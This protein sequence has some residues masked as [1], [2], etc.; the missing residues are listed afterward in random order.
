VLAG[1]VRWVGLERTFPD[2]RIDWL[3]NHSLGTPQATN[4][5]VWALNRHADLTAIAQTYALTKNE[6]YAAG[7][8]RLLRSWISQVPAPSVEFEKPGSAWRRLEAGLRT[9]DAWLPA[10]ALVRQSPELSDDDLLLFLRACWDH[11]N[12]LRSARYDPTNHFVFAMSGLYSVGSVLPELRDAATWRK[13]AGT[14]LDRLLG[15]GVLADG[16]WWELAPGYGQWVCDKLI[17]VWNRADAQGLDAEITPRSRQALQRL[18]EWGVLLMAPERTVPRLNDGVLLRHRPESVTALAK[19]FP[20]SAILRWLANDLAGQPTVPPAQTS[21][22][23]NASGYQVMR[24]GWSRDDSYLVLDAGALG[25]WHGHQDALNVVAWFHGR[26]F[27]FDN[28][29]FKYDASIWRAW[30]QTTA[31]HNTVLVDGLGQIRSWNGHEDP[32]GLHPAGQP[33]PRFAKSPTADYGSAW[34][35]CGYGASVPQRGKAASQLRSDPATHRREVVFAKGPDPYALVLDT[36]QPA[37]QLAHRYEVRW[38][39]KSV[40]WRTA[41][42]GRI[43]WTSDP[44]QPNLA[45]VSLAGADRW[46]ADSGVTDPEPLGWWFENQN[47]DPVPALTLRHDVTTAGP[48]RLLTALIPFRADPEACPVLGLD[49]PDASTAV[50]RLRDGRTLTIHLTGAAT[51]PGLTIDH[52][53]LP[54]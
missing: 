28:G 45:I 38:H 35:A 20:D 48:V 44:G 32:I 47:A 22:D 2:G 18:A 43:T 37:D 39:L 4:E 6:R 14:Q 10:F 17:G 16:S 26:H 50:I 42:N 3:A 29:G 25:G 12:F 33:A 1:E 21:V 15:D 30:G 36:L 54:E 31:A 11:A 46:R 51:G 34:Y 13:I 8:I 19:R 40:Q 24:T 41:D 5:W 27:L 49:R 53:P 52:L 7:W 23:L 9:T